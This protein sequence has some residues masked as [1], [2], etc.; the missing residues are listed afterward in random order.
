MSR[1]L[2]VQT[3]KPCRGFECK[4]YE[5]KKYPNNKGEYRG[6]TIKK[7]NMTLEPISHCEKCEKLNDCEYCIH[8]QT[9][10]YSVAKK[11]NKS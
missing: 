5:Y 11:E 7:I 3:N 10:K 9:C 2:E 1:R 8:S 4:G 6:C